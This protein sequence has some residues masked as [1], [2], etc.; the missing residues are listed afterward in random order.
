VWGWAARILPGSIDPVF[1][2]G[3]VH[4]A[5]FKVVWDGRQFDRKR[6]SSKDIAIESVICYVLDSI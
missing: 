6:Q 2:L 4:E 3:H 5:A 1:A